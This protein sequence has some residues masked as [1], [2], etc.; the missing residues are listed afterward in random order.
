VDIIIAGLWTKKAETAAA[1][2]ENPE[3]PTGSL[4]EV[5][6]RHPWITLRRRLPVLVEN[7]FRTILLSHFQPV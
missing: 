5:I 1:I 3:K 7:P 6:H 4:R 2:G